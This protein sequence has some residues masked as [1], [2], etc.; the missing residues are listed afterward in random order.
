MNTTGNTHFIIL[1]INNI[2]VILHQVKMNWHQFIKYGNTFDTLFVKIN[3]ITVEPS[4][5]VTSI[6]GHTI[7]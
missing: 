7:Y 2:R 5:K 6:V 4:C 1:H 3:S